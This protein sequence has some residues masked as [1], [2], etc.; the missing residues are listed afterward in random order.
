MIFNNSIKLFIVGNINEHHLIEIVNQNLSNIE[1]AHSS[2][3]NFEKPKIKEKTFYLVDKKGSAQSEL[4][5]GHIAKTRNSEDYYPTKI[6]NTIL[7][8]QFS[9]R[10]NLNLREKKG[11][12]YG[13]NSSFGY[14]K[15]T[16]IF[17]ISTAVNIDNT[18]DSIKEIFFE[19]EEIQKNINQ[20]EIDFAKSYLIKQFPSKFETY[21]QVAKNI[22]SIVTHNLSFDEFN[23]YQSNIK[24]VETN[25]VLKAARENILNEYL[26][27]VIVG[28][29]QKVIPQIEKE[30]NITP[31]E[32]DKEGNEI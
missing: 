32:L 21:S 9:S 20:E 7:G 26:T 24:N 30:F 8:G 2:N 5:I 22:E 11:Y 13:A 17:E 6:M 16:G 15:H 23:T 25:E 14:F 31:T 10:I 4:R 29:K 1:S 27:I 12:T 18:S 28:D 3:D 19:I